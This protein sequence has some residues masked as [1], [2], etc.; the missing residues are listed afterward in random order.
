MEA[1]AMLRSAAFHVSNP[2][3]VRGSQVRAARALLN[4]SLPVTAEKC[5]I[6]TNTI[7]RLE[8]GHRSPGDEILQQMVR[9]FE[10]HGVLF[11]DTDAGTGVL[12]TDRS[13]THAPAE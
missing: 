5:G 10:E 4:W 3:L 11:I 1:S 7:S 6:G 8:K 13:R 12:L 9:V 2:E